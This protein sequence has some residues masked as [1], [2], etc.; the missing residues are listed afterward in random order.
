MNGSK[1]IYLCKVCETTLNS[2]DKICPK[3]KTDL[4]KT[5]RKISLSLS[6]SI[7]MSDKL[8]MK[9]VRQGALLK[10]DADSLALIGIFFT[11]AIG[12]T[13]LLDIMIKNLI[14]SGIV[15]LTLTILLLIILTKIKFVK[16]LSIR[17]SRWF[18][19]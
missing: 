9:F 12:L 11:I 16:D 7:K 14:I 2:Q 19:K 18:L 8:F 5:G 10:W 17:F 1:A 15:G 6:D 4:S 3:C 13:P